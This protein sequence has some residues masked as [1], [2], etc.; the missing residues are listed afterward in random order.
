VW[1]NPDIPK[2]DRLDIEPSARLMADITQVQHKVKLYV[3]AHKKFTR[4][5]SPYMRIF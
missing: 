4:P 5:V 2:Y 1:A 3:A